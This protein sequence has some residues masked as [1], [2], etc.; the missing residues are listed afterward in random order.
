MPSHEVLQS[1]YT[2]AALYSPVQQ[3]LLANLQLKQVLIMDGS[4]GKKAKFVDSLHPPIPAKYPR[5]ATIEFA[6]SFIFPPPLGM[7]GI[8][9]CHVVCRQD[10]LTRET[11][12]LL[13]MRSSECRR[14]VGVAIFGCSLHTHSDQLS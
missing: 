14:A 11:C 3:Y 1:I 9:S 2:T 8:A 4:D 13:A 7:Q 6:A 10:T 5:Y 12:A